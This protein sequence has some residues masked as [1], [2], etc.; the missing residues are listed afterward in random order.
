MVRRLNVS[1][2]LL[3]L[4]ALIPMLARLAG[5][6]NSASQTVDITYNAPWTKYCQMGKDAT[7][8]KVC[9]TSKSGRLKSGMPV[10]SAAIIEPEG[11][12]GILRVTLPLGM[13][14]VHGTRIIVD[15]NAPQQ[16]P[17][18]VCF[19]NGCMSDYKMA[20]ENIAAIRQGQTLVVQAINSNG[21]PLTLPLPLADFA[22]AYD[23]PATGQTVSQLPQVS[24]PTG[25]TTNLTSGGRDGDGISYAS[26]D[27][28]SRQP[29]RMDNSFGVYSVPVRFNDTITIDAVVDSGAADVT[30]PADLVLTL[31]QTR[32]VTPEDFLGKQTYILADGSKIPSQQFRLRSLKVGGRTVENVVASIATST[33]AP[34]LLGQSFLSKFKS[35]SVDN[36][37]HTLILR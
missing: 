14:L 13:Q 27:S 23:G 6:A 11:K 18:V 20:P 34:I 28:A 35:W 32:T 19:K 22:T 33:D 10:V 16:S 17:Y 21:A 36:E 31:V 5:A 15:N 3:A 24:H 8:Q 25:P 9:F 2:F 12:P 30:I 37:Q 26:D 7:A 29:I 4:F 1:L